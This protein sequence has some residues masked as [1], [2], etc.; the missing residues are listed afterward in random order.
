MSGI[1][2]PFYGELDTKCDTIP[3]RLVTLA[4]G[5]SLRP[6]SSVQSFNKHHHMTYGMS[7]TLPSPGEK[8]IRKAMPSGDLDTDT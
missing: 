5:I 6:L 1:N 2:D 4:M 7:D 3:S 8:G